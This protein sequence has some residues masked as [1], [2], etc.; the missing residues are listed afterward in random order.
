MQNIIP[1]LLWIEN[2]RDLRDVVAT[3]S[4][5][6]QAVVDLAASEVPVGYPRD[7]AYLRLPLEDGA[8]NS[9]AVVRLAIHVTAELIVAQIPA[10]VAC[11]MGMSRSP[12]IV[13]AALSITQQSRF[14]QALTSVAGS[15]PI[16]VSPGLVATIRQAIAQP[17]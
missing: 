11:S 6:V 4:L 9:P 7:I 2:S 15:G 5:N 8:D 3:L 1:H 16:D 12:A 14:E 13:A 17:E 10:L